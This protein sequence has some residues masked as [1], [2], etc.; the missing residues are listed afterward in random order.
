MCVC[1]CVCVCVV[2]IYIYIYIYI[3]ICF[4]DIQYLPEDDQVRLK[5]V[6]IMTDCVKNIILPLVFLVFLLR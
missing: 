2:Y 5:Y 4:T 3:H 1:V 6:G